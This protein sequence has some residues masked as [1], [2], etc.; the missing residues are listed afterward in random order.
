MSST[1]EQIQHLNMFGGMNQSLASH[2]T[3]EDAWWVQF[4]MRRQVQKGLVQ[5][6]RKK[7]LTTN[8]AFAPISAIA[9]VP[10]S[11][12]RRHRIFV[13]GSQVGELKADN[14]IAL[15]PLVGP[16]GSTVQTS[17][18]GMSEGD[19]WATVVFDGNIYF[20]SLQN[21]L[22]KLTG[23]PQVERMGGQ[24]VLVAPSKTYPAARYLEVFFDHLVF[25]NVNFNGI[26]P[27][28]VLWSGLRD[29]GDYVPRK[30]SETD[31]F[32]FLEKESPTCDGMTG[33]KRYGD[34]LVG[35]TAT[36]IWMTRYVGLPSVF[37][38][39]EIVMDVGNDFPYALVANDKH[40]IFISDKWQNFLYF[41]GSNTPEP[42]GDPIAQYFFDTLTDEPD[43][44]YS[45]FGYVN[46]RY[47]ELCWAYISKDSDGVFD[48]E[49]VFS[50][51]DKK[52][53]VRSLEDCAAFSPEVFGI[54]TIDDLTGT[55]ENL[56]GTI[57]S[58]GD[59]QIHTFLWARLD[60]SLLTEAAVGDSN[61]V[62]QPIP[63]LETGDYFYGDLESMKEMETML[64]QAV[65]GTASAVQ[66]LYST[67][68]NLGDEIKWTTLPQL[69]TP[70]IREGRLSLPRVNGRIFRFRFQ[71][72]TTEEDGVDGF[73]WQ[74]FVENVYGTKQ[75][76]K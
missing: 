50:I 64:V 38:W 68:A 55:I 72:Y 37:K 34:I 53:H 40:H 7:I 10:T 14:T 48:K 60:G 15:L 6:P 30:E 21:Q 29:F 56:T 61:V 26:F 44:R 63:Y 69:W 51:R 54:Q 75:V 39:E 62:A 42:I 19:R 45:L 5:V 4:G 43:D 35:Y 66:V 32:D 28:R 24:N 22:H 2:L 36:G 74:G 1:K 3:P 8:A 13:F 31:Y 47:R 23:H 16:D 67:R 17:E 73:S 59:G 58:L 41:N 33:L 76:E 27:N 57:N 9:I 12:G 20:T 71:P 65:L 11:L 18:F 49:V 25:G 46:T 70:E 52:W